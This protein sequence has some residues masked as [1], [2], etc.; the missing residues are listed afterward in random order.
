M[1]HDDAFGSASAL[2]LTGCWEKLIQV[3]DATTGALLRTLEAS[4]ADTERKSHAESL[5][6]QLRIDLQQFSGTE[7]DAFD[8]GVASVECDSSL[9]MQL[10]VSMA[11]L[12]DGAFATSRK[13]GNATG[14][15]RAA[16]SA[17]S[18]VPPPFPRNGTKS[19]PLDTA[20]AWGALGRRF[21]RLS[22]TGSQFQ[23]KVDL[24]A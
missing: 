15:L 17:D 24:Q 2:L 13:H 4:T 20:K 6:S 1:T 10:R 21:R 7:H 11:S 5:L 23:V 18:T 19:P 12:A 3:W 8:E 16:P 22:D 9:L 14:A